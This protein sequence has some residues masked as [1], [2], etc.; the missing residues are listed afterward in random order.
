MIAMPINRLMAKLTATSPQV[1]KSKM[2]LRAEVPTA[3]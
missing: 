3:V 1:L 2:K